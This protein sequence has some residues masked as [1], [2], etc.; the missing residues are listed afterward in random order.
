MKNTLVVVSLATV[1]TACSTTSMETLRT[2]NVT[3]REV[4]TVLQAK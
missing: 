4:P 3:K 2:E 1:L